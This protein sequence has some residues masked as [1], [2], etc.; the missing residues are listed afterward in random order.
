MY[1][2]GVL[3]GSEEVRMSCRDVEADDHLG[4]SAQSQEVTCR[5][6]ARSNACVSSL[7]EVSC[8]TQEIV[9]A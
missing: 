2:L 4:I 7:D 9:Y 3:R 5:S 6:C 8:K 1:E